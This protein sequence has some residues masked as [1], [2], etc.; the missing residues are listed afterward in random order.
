M[1]IRHRSDVSHI[2]I[3][4]VKKIWFNFFIYVP[5]R[6]SLSLKTKCRRTVLLPI[7]SKG[8]FTVEVTKFNGTTVNVLDQHVK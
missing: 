6:D 4:H 7:L 3:G 8:T 1:T 5:K 2:I